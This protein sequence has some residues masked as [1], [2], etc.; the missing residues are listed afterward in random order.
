MPD[1]LLVRSDDSV[2]HM[3][4]F[5]VPEGSFMDVTAEIEV[6]RTLHSLMTAAP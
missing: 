4:V 2:L 5:A 6:E 1:K 3:E